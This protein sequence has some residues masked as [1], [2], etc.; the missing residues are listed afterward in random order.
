M[1]FLQAW[2]EALKSCD[3][4]ARTDKEPNHAAC[5]SDNDW[6]AWYGRRT[7]LRFSKTI[8]S[9]LQLS[10]KKKGTQILPID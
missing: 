3:C 6:G 8:S 1:S 7:C 5:F 4:G 10:T 9:C 2:R